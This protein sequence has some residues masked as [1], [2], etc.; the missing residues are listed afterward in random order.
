MT[1]LIIERKKWEEKCPGVSP[2][3]HNSSVKAS[4]MDRGGEAKRGMVSRLTSSNLERTVFQLYLFASQVATVDVS[5]WAGAALH[6]SRPRSTGSR[7]PS[8][9]HQL[10]ACNHSRGHAK[11]NL[12]KPRI[13]PTLSGP[14]V[15][16]VGPA[17]ATAAAASSNLVWI[18]VRRPTPGKVL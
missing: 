4:S 13:F 10:S 17:W 2:E 18:K 8:E 14:S 12:T 15:R 16:G 3:R 11:F 9:F 1:R 7:P 6:L 5:D